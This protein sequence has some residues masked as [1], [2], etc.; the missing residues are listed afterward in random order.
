ML[1]LLDML[2]G[3]FLI[4]FGGRLDRVL[5]YSGLLFGLLQGWYLP[6]GIYQMFSYSVSLRSA[7]ISKT[8]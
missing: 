7:G 2:P 1:I 4:I 5:I 6:V 8:S 3:R